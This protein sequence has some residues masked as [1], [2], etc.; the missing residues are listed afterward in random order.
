MP[1]N[2]DLKQPSPAAPAGPLVVTSA[3]L[4]QEVAETLRT[5]DPNIFISQIPIEVLVI[6][7]S[8]FRVVTI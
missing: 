8:T 3:L 7:A 5:G 4:S 6:R 1:Q 2:S